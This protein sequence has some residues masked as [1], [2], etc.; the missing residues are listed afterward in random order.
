MLSILVVCGVEKTCAD[1]TVSGGGAAGAVVTI[2][3][4]DAERL[5]ELNRLREEAMLNAE[6]MKRLELELEASRK[7]SA[8]LEAELIELRNK[9]Q[10]ENE[11]GRQLQLWL[12]GVRAEGTVRKTGEREEQQLQAIGKL[13]ED[14]VGLALDAVDFCDQVQILLQEL[15]IGKV[16]Q[17]QYRLKLDN[18]ARKARRFIAMAEGPDEPGTGMDALR[19]CRILAVNREQ[20]VVVLSVGSVK[21]AF[22]GMIYHVGKDREEQ[23]K[24]VSV[25][26]SVAAAVLIRGSIEK[27]SPGME[28]AAGEERAGDE[29]GR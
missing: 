6:K 8:E 15:P 1:E 10:A 7:A 14:G 5:R 26:P 13:S 4:N 25:R 29:S 24:V 16:R 12:A 22:A 27:L 21:G 17:A 19:T 20:R 28:A 2:R 18:L 23:L 9:L 11:R 3:P